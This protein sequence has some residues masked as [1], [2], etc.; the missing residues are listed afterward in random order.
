MCES[1]KISHDCLRKFATFIQFHTVSPWPWPSLGR[2]QV[3]AIHFQRR[4]LRARGCWGGRHGGRGG[5]SQGGQAVGCHSPAHGLPAAVY[6]IVSTG[7]THA[8]NNSAS[9]RNVIFLIVF[10]SNIGAR[11]IGFWIIFALA[12]LN[13]QARTLG[14]PPLPVRT[15]PPEMLRTVRP[16]PRSCEASRLDQTPCWSCTWKRPSGNK[17]KTG[18]DLQA[19]PTC[20]NMCQPCKAGKLSI[21]IELSIPRHCMSFPRSRAPVKYA[22][23]RRT[24]GTTVPYSSYLPQLERHTTAYHL[25]FQALQEVA[26]VQLG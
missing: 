26:R 7:I 2:S 5:R 1:P 25:L 17:N 9:K 8:S 24:K 6:H 19:V 18:T 23:A 3:E 12:G 15:Q 22:G 11:S 16:A 21:I 10:S 4:F 14:S 13:L 20:A